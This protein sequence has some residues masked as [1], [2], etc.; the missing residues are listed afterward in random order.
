MKANEINRTAESKESPIDANAALAVDVVVFSVREADDP[1]D[2]WQVLLVKS[3]K[4]VF[5]GKRA[6]PGV[7]VRAPERFEEAALRALRTKT[8][9]D[10]GDW[11]LEQ[12]G[13]WGEPGRDT[14]GRVASVAYVALVRSDHLALVAGN[15]VVDAEWVPVREALREELAFDHSEMLRAAVSRVRSKLRYSWVAFQL[16]PDQ[17]T[18]P[19]LRAVYASILDPS[20][21]RLN[22]SNFKRAFAQLFESGAL[23][24]TGER[25]DAQ[26]RGRPGDLY[27]F[28]GPLVGTWERELPWHS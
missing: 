18:L 10:A 7:L 2:A 3:S 27:R 14:R 28:S 11:Y 15:T 4:R 23:V 8:G 12:L 22:S 21:A 26:G 16:L 1:G 13:T 5:D 25:A 20:V 17:F 19:E 24:P 9:L 6:L